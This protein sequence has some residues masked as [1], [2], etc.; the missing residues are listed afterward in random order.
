MLFRSLWNTVPQLCFVTVP[1][2]WE[3]SGKRVGRDSETVVAANPQARLHLTYTPPTMRPHGQPP[4][5]AAAGGPAAARKK[6]K[7]NDR[8]PCASGKK[9]KKCCGA[10]AAVAARTQARAAANA[11]DQLPAGSH[12]DKGLALYTAGDY[13]VRK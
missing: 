2:E 7:P 4:P 3:Y 12:N 10:P 5:A 6:A 8:C 1:K 13:R 11:L 9:Y